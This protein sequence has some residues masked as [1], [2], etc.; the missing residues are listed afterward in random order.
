VRPHTQYAKSGDVHIAYQVL[1]AGQIDVV[2]VHGLL[3]H[4][5]AFWDWPL[6][7]RFMERLGSFARV[8]VFDKR[9]VGLSD[10]V[11][12][13]PTFTERMDDVRAVMDAAGSER[14]AVFGV[15]EG[16][17]MS[18]LFAATH[19]ER[20]PALVLYGGMARTTWAED[21]PYGP[22]LEATM[23]AM[24]ELVQP[25]FGGEVFLEM[26]APSLEGDPVEAEA[27]HRRILAAASPGTI[28]ALWDMAVQ[29]DVRP[30]LPSIRCPTLVMHRKGDRIASV[31][32]ARWMAEQIP[33]ARYVELP[34]G[35]HFPWIGD[36]D[37]VLGE[38]E[39]FLTGIRAVTVPDSVL[40]TVLF[41]DIVGS[42]ERAVE[43]GDEAW[44]R[45]LDRHHEL[46][47]RYLERFQGREV[48]TA[49]DGFLAT[50]DGPA[51]AVRCAQALTDAVRELGLEIRAGVHTGEVELREDGVS[52][53][54]VHV[55]ARVAALAQAGEVLVTRTVKD[56]VAGSGITFTDRGTH[57]LKGVPDEWQLYVAASS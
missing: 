50:F 29:I 41:T 9:G 18:A 22:P 38:V 43:L 6:H 31:H 24:G 10:R 55:G 21:Y 20:V 49:G 27:W 52:G 2:L 15:S 4:L 42:T 45:L 8:I 36:Q 37:A 19:P 16:A 11:A 44:R 40:L 30:V 39:Q 32:G 35:D 51:R 26:F 54:A 57:E 56:L 17:P 1:G 48:D 46:V 12:D 53:L 7:A 13:L 28:E 14:A 3:S 33:G 5:D 25:H 47:R 34:G 23:E